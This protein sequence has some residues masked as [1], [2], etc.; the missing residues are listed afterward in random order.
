V[1]DAQP[2][3]V[4]SLEVNDLRCWERLEVELPGGLIVIS[5]PNGAGKT[6]I[7]EAIVLAT[8]G[9]SPRTAQLADLVR[10]GAPA[11]RVTGEFDDPG[12]PSIIVR[13]E[14]GY[15]VGVGRRLSLDGVGVRQLMTWRRPSAVLVFVPEEL[16]AVKGPPAARRRSLDRLLE[17]IAP[18]FAEDL[19]GYQDALSQ[20]NALLRRARTGG[21]DVRT[22][23]PWEA[24]MAT[25]GARVLTARRAAIAALAPRYAYWLERLGGGSHGGLAWEPSPAILIETPDQA[26]EDR[27]RAHFEQ[28]RPRDLAAGLTTSGPH[29]DDMWIGSGARDLRRL[30]S[31]GEQRTAALALLLAYRDQMRMTG[32]GPI[33]LLDDV[34]SELDPDRRAAVLGALEG[35]EQVILTSADPETPIQGTSREATIFYVRDGAC[36]AA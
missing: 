19:A 15:A 29:R 34:L 31:Q 33:L 25:L 18:S 9:V 12:S 2:W 30:G 11:V 16:R 35:D 8:L 5:G 7:V 22:A 24:R 13:R 1:S 23:F 28:R 14:I 32:P 36:N 21:A 20:R 27:L 10:A 26:L 6:S 17:A 4:R 3:R